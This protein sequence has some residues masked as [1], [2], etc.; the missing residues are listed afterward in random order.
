M[1]NNFEYE[2]MLLLVYNHNYFMNFN[3]NQT[4]LD[5]KK[6]KMRVLIFDKPWCLPKNFSLRKVHVNIFCDTFA[7]LW[8]FL[9]IGLFWRNYF[10]MKLFCRS[11][12][13]VKLF[14]RE[15]FCRVSIMWKNSTINIQRLK[16]SRFHK[17]NT[18]KL[19]I[20]CTSHKS[21]LLKVLFS[22]TYTNV[23]ILS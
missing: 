12:T 1:S 13:V 6:T 11:Y 4:I 14:C 10:V 22:E 2:N 19:K 16:M 3:N 21:Y 8:R 15:L 7:P 20:L 9:D 17:K 23:Y 5:F 18:M